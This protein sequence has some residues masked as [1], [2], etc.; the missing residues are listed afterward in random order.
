MRF[1]E[2]T[3]EE[4]R[5]M[6]EHYPTEGGLVIKR[7]PGRSKGTIYAKANKLNLVVA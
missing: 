2:W 4:R 3:V 1:K 6:M 7:L 5:I